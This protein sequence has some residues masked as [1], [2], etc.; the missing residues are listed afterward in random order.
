MSMVASR[1]SM[2][3]AAEEGPPPVMA[4]LNFV[5]LLKYIL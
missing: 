4:R 1:S 5:F 2:L 3:V